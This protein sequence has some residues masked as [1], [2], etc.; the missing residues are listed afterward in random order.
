MLSSKIGS[1]AV[2]PS[3]SGFQDFISLIPSSQVR[4]LLCVHLHVPLLLFNCDVCVAGVSQNFA[5][6]YTIPI[7]QLGFEFEVMKTEKEVQ[8]KPEDGAYVWVSI[9]DSVSMCQPLVLN[10]IYYCYNSKRCERINTT[11]VA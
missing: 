11:S 10:H 3:V 2:H 9:T 1:T 6:K 5:R 8:A 7:D 4:Y